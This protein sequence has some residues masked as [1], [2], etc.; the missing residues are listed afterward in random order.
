MINIINKVKDQCFL[1]YL[2]IKLSVLCTSSDVHYAPV[3]DDI[4]PDCGGVNECI[5]QARP[6]LIEQT[7]GGQQRVKVTC[8]VK[9]N[10]ESKLPAKSSTTASQ[11]YLPNQVQQRV[12]V[13]CQIMCN[14]ESKLP[15]KSC[16]TASQSYLPNQVQQRVKVTC[17]MKYN[18][19][20]KLPAK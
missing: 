18:S 19:E 13:T 9:Y 17:Q 1:L 10:S 11:S 5:W 4:I 2:N 20:S 8:Q 16:A 15:A 14:S 7:A 6:P 12:K 3:G